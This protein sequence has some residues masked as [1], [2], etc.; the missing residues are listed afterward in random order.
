VKFRAAALLALLTLGGSP[1]T[2]LLCGFSCVRH[3]HPPA[4]STAAGDDACHEQAPI[5]GGKIR[6]A[7]GG[8]ANHAEGIASIATTSASQNRDRPA[9]LPTRAPLAVEAAHAIRPALRVHL[10]SSGLTAVAIPLRI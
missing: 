7:A 2:G 6:A 10:R 5:G 3:T 4:D 8:C 9:V 1:L